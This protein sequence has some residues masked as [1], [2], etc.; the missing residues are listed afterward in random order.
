MPC[1]LWGAILVIL[2]AAVPTGGAETVLPMGTAP[3]P[4]ALPHFPN[5]LYAFVWRNWQV[6]E[7]RK[8]AEVLGTSVDNVVALA[9]SMGLPPATAVPREMT[10]R[11]YITILR[12]NWHLLPYEQLLPL[13]DMS[14]E[15]LAYALREDDFL[16]IKL[17][18]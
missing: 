17:G 5:R 15:Q 10:S 8:M 1:K 4:V 6:V 13:V 12:R 9:E 7:P 2:A 11:G 3:A 16:W 14:A 18:C